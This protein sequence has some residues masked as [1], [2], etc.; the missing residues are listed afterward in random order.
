MATGGTAGPETGAAG[1][2][3]CKERAN[4]PQRGYRRVGLSTDEPLAELNQML[5][6]ISSP[7][8][9]KNVPR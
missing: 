9:L 6:R 3:A 5:Q 7:C 2:L 4:G 1:P 8:A